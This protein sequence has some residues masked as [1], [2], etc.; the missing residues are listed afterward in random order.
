MAKEPKDPPPLISEIGGN[1]TSLKKDIKKAVDEI[2][3]L[4]GERRGI[5]ERITEIKNHLVD[6]GIT[7][8]AITRAIQ[9]YEREMQAED[10]AEGQRKRQG[11]DEAYCIV[12]ETMGLPG[13]LGLFD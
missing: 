7:K 6:K 12:R 5:S 10:T 4:Q 11:D 13:Q 1:L 3:E 8:R 2:L 9:D